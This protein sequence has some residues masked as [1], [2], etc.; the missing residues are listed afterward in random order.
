[1][2][3]L[4]PGLGIRLKIGPG[5]C[6]TDARQMLADHPEATEETKPEAWEALCSYQGAE[7]DF[8]VTAFIAVLV[9]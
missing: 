2:A 4:P 5:I 1:M 9:L 6:Y 3:A 7:R 8:R